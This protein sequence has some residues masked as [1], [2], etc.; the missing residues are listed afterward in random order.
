M[1]AASSFLG[2]LPFGFGPSDGSPLTASSAVP[3]AV[4]AAAASAGYRQGNRRSMRNVS[5]ARNI[6]PAPAMLA[7]MQQR[8]RLP[9]ACD[10]R[11]CAHTA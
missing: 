7:S 1:A 4:G 6:M 3:L 8:R 9:A 2:A 5:S 11:A 10:A